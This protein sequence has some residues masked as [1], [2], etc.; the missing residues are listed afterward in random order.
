MRKSSAN[1]IFQGLA[2]FYNALVSAGLTFFVGR[3][4]GPEKFGTYSYILTIASFFLILQ[5]GG[6]KTLLFREKTRTS[7]C[8]KCGEGTLFAVALGHTFIVST[9]GF[10]LIAF[11]PFPGKKSLFAAFFCFGLQAVVNFITAELRGSGMFSR[12]ALWQISVRTVS[13]V[14]ILAALYLLVHEPWAVFTGWAVGNLFGLFCSPV[15]FALPRFEGDVLRKVRKACISFIAIDAAT[16]LYFRADILLLEHLAKDPA[17]VGQYAAAY[18]FL[19]GV[20]LLA[21]PIGVICFRELRLIYDNRPLFLRKIFQL[22][23]LMGGAAIFLLLT[24]TLGGDKIVLWTFGASYSGAIVLLP[25]LFASLFFVLPNTILTRQLLRTIM[26]VSMR[27]PPVQE[28]WLM[29]A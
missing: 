9:L 5:D 26:S 2:T 12:D 11:L 1:L 15:S 14:C 21:A 8:L 22:V 18:R 24:V 29:L 27:L 4:L 3:V 16:I 23:F 25:W 19:E 17:E 20:I 7:G 13:G 28:P 10:F 6:F